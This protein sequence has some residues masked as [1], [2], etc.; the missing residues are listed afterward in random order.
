MLLLEDVSIVGAIL[1]CYTM[2]YSNVAEVILTSSGSDMRR[3]DRHGP[4]ALAFCSGWTYF[5]YKKTGVW[6]RIR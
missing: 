1:E 2:Q 3:W 6:H 4:S 5:P